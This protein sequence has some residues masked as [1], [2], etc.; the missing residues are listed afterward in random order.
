MIK[1]MRHQ[2]AVTPHFVRGEVDIKYV[3][4]LEPFEFQNWV[5]VDKFLGTISRTKSGD[6]GID[7]ITPQLTGGFPIQ[8]KQSPDV[9]RNVI[10]NF[11]TAMRRVKKKKGYIVAFSFGKGSYEEAARVKNQEDL[12]I[13]LRTVQELL[14]GK[15]EE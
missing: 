8:V 9:G 11:Q 2:Y 12:H 4:K 13:I 3:K 15:V 5:V 7:G 1:R 10:D 14:D 6:M